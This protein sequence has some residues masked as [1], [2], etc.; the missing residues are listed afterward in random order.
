M[1]ESQCNIDET[2]CLESFSERKVAAPNHTLSAK[3][4]LVATGLMHQDNPRRV[5][6]FSDRLLSGSLR[7]DPS[8]VHGVA[9]QMLFEINLLAGKLLILQH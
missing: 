8:D 4:P 9:N 7:L 3:N 5:R 2:A 6:S 1:E